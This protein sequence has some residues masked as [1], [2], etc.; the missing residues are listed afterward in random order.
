MLEAMIDTLIVGLIKRTADQLGIKV[1]VKVDK[2]SSSLKISLRH[3][4]SS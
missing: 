2:K 4:D 3:A 1:T